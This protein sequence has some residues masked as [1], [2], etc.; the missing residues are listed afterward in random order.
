MTGRPRRAPKTRHIPETRHA[1]E[2]RGRRGERLAAAYLQL[3]GYRILARD[4]RTAVGQVD[5]VAKRGDT[6]V[7]VEVKW[8]PTLAQAADAIRP[9]Q[10]AR[11]ARAAGAIRQRMPAVGGCNVRFDAV[12]LAPRRWPRHIIDAWR[13]G[14]ETA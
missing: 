10:R 12:L 11:I 14:E 6:L 5:V 3:K 8:R 7:L 1:A 13:T 4:Y 9:T 2:A